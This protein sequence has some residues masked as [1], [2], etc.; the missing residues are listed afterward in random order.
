MNHVLQVNDRILVRLDQ[1]LDPRSAASYTQQC[2]L[3]LL[4]LLLLLLLLSSL[5]VSH[6]LLQVLPVA[7]VVRT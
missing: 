4:Q 1:W 3:L 7:V 5:H 2:C 6:M